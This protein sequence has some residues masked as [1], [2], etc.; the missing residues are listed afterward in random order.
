MSGMQF[1]TASRCRG[2]AP[3]RQRLRHPASLVS[4]IGERSAA[5]SR[6]STCRPGT[7]AASTSRDGRCRP[8]AW[9][10]PQQRAKPAHPVEQQRATSRRR[11]QRCGPTTCLFDF[12]LFNFAGQ[13]TKLQFRLEAINALNYTVC[14]TRTQTRNA[15]FGFI[16]RTATPRDLQLGLRFTFWLEDGGRRTKRRKSFL[17]LFPS[18]PSTS[19]LHYWSD[20]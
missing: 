16:T 17:E 9:T 6:G 11:S 8:T 15:T 13:G 12:G 18:P 5:A 3:L 7:S 19:V 10:I 4:N 1:R 14:G 20:H 2:P